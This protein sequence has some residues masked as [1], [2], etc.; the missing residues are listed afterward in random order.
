M[1]EC[2]AGC[3][4]LVSLLHSDTKKRSLTTRREAIAQ[5]YAHFWDYVKRLKGAL[6]ALKYLMIPK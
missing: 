5:L 3:S 6:A 4:N 2:V 1:G